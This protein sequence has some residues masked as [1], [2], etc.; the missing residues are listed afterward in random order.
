LLQTGFD[1]LER[2]QS[3]FRLS[4]QALPKPVPFFIFSRFE[5]INDL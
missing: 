3:S 1:R 2:G 5:Q 4:A